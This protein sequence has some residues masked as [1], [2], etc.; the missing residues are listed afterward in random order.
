MSQSNLLSSVW[1]FQTINK[2]LNVDVPTGTKRNWNISSHSNSNHEGTGPS[3]WQIDRVVFMPNSHS[4]FHYICVIVIAK[5]PKWQKQTKNMLLLPMS[6]SPL[7]ITK[8][9]LPPLYQFKISSTCKCFYRDK[10][11]IIICLHS[12]YSVQCSL[13]SKSHW[14]DLGD[15][16]TPLSLS[17]TDDLRSLPQKTSTDIFTHWSH[18]NIRY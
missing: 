11:I 15:Y 6:L 5:S 9:N 1:Y 7:D 2:N 12:Y 16:P 13:S 4:R 17:R 14:S 18:N 8:G 3:K 10:I